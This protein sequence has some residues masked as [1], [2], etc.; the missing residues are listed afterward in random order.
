M[1]VK[2]CGITNGPDAE[3]AVEAGADALGFVFYSQSPRAVDV[4]VAAAVI[5]ALPPFV[6]KVGV[7]VDAALPTILEIAGQCGLDTI[8]LHGGESPELCGRI[9]L[10]TIKAFRVQNEAVLAELKRFNTSAWLLDGYV[11]GQPGGTGA[12]FNWT[13]ARQACALGRPVILAGGLTPANIREA[14]R[15]VRPYGVDVSSGV[16]ARAGKK[17]FAKLRDFL[18]AAKQPLAAPG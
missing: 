10:K 4:E 14:I 15:Q 3:A 17:D 2:I 11:A 9:P 12:T 8:Q 13:I 18:A 16:E 1:K 5:R 7:F 6:A